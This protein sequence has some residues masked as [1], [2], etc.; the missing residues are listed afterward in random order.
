MNHEQMIETSLI[1]LSMHI[2]LDDSQK[3]IIK[4]EM[5][6]I[7]SFGLSQGRIEQL[8]KQLEQLTKLQNTIAG[9]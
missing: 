9:R 5:Q 7:L 8:E 4:N 6:R 3:D 2:V 1:I